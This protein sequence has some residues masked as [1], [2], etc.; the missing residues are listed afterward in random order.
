MALLCLFSGTAVRAQHTGS[1]DTTVMF[2]GTPRAVSL[3]VPTSYTAGIAHRL[4]VC[5]HGLGDTC[6]AY[7]NAL[8]SSLAWPTHLANTILVCP[9]AANRNADYYYPAGG[10]GIIQ[11]AIDMAMETYHI[12]TSDVI[13]QGFSLGGRAALR[14]GLDHSSTFKGLLLNT[15]AIQGV[16]EAL[17]DGGYTFN[18]ANAPQIPVYITHGAD[19]ILYT[20]PIDSMYRQLILHDGIVKLNRVPGVAH[21]IPAFAAMNEF[22]PYFD[23]PAHAGGDADVVAVSIAK[24]SCAVTLPAAC[25][26]RNTGTDT[27]SAVN[28][29][30]VAAGS[31]FSHSWTG[32]LAPYQHTWVTLPDVTASTGIHTLTV[33]VAG[34]NA[35]I[36]DTVTAN[37]EQSAPFQIATSGNSLPVS[38]GFEA[39]VFPPANWI[40]RTSGDIYCAWDRDNTVRKTGI[41]SMTSFN[42]ILLFDNA[43]R[44]D[45]MESP[46]LD[47]TSVSEPHVTFDV[48]YNY[49]RYTPPAT[50]V[51]TVFA[52]TL[53][54]M[55]STD[56]GTTYTT[57][58]KKGGAELAT[59]PL[60]ILNALSV[61]A[62]FI[63]PSAANWRTE[64]IDLGAYSAA[65]GV[66]VKFS[67]KSALGGSINIDN[68]NFRNGPAGVTLQ[69]GTGGIRLFPNPATDILHV[70]APGNDI[71]ELYVTDMAGRNVLNVSCLTKQ[72]HVET[73]VSTL[74]SGVYI[75]RVQCGSVLYTEK[76]TIAR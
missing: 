6:N 36:T 60:P 18:Y 12:D 2:S 33:T 22:L 25:L 37:N 47:L 58:Y 48:A 74:P 55:V 34:I 24:R 46:V 72:Q 10:E 30:C 20:G 23:T 62:A 64:D 11:A 53:S 70:T 63:N 4:M 29:T 14:Y 56:C 71:T 19:D 9:E 61:P 13:L 32:T 76:L 17:N 42:S 73:R 59:F 66:I 39:V 35:G 49:H 68:V 41:A 65:N 43:G 57:V 8:V 52:D 38:E 16:K 3:Y 45:E 28:L 5:L 7:R 54:V 26:I 21:T 27:L 67:Y 40:Q 1:Y 15:P 31:T 69:A 75:V 44:V 50:T 51:D